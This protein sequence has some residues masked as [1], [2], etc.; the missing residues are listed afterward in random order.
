[1]KHR[2]RSF[3]G[4]A[5]LVV[6]CAAAPGDP[7]AYADPPSA[8]AP[9]PAAGP[10][11]K[12]AAM[13]LT[14]TAPAGWTVKSTGTET[15]PW[16][17]LAVFSAP[18]TQVEV[19]VSQRDRTFVS[20]DALHAA[21]QKQWASDKAFTLAG[22][23]TVEPS[24]LRPVGMVQVEAT[25]VRTPPPATPGAAPAPAAMPVVWNVLVAYVLAQRNEIVVYA[26]SP[27]AAFGRARSSVQALFDS[28]VLAAPPRGAEGEGAYRNDERGFSVRYPKAYTV[29]VPQRRDHVV[30]FV[31][32][33][34]DQAV[35]D[36]FLIEWKESTAKDA[37][38]LVAHF[39]DAR[40]GESSARTG[41]VAGQPGMIVTAQVVEAGRESTVVLALLK[42]GDELFRLRASFPRTA[43]ADGTAAFQEFL[44]SF[45][46]TAAR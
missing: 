33:S 9:A 3:L 40:G 30:S 21:V 12:N 29:V 28:I 37:D 22:V 10:V 19:T 42:R 2:A 16:R 26:T 1:V 43:E 35:L 8:P 4:P 45:A 34:A 14:I 7:R 18:G 31:P 46:L 44:K 23:R 38:R 13:G 39:K 24:A 5:L 36:V 15:V 17:K 27:A 25:H 20:L 6:V 11:Y 41:D 32:T